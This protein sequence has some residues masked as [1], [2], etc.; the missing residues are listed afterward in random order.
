MAKGQIPT[1]S[2]GGTLFSVIRGT[3]G[4]AFRSSVTGTVYVSLSDQSPMRM[5]VSLRRYS[6]SQDCIHPDDYLSLQKIPPLWR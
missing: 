6:R 3:R 5:K 1:T 4:V 2:G